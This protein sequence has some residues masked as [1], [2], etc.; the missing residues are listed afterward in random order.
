MFAGSVAKWGQPGTYQQTLRASDGIARHRFGWS[1]AA[2]GVS[3]L[4]GAPERS[5][6][7]KSTSGS[8]YVFS[9]GGPAQ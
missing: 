7:Q 1:V 9:N 4:V 8:A 5:V 6:D 2:S 3:A